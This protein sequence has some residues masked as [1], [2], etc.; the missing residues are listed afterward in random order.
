MDMNIKLKYNQVRMYYESGTGGS[1]CICARQT[2]HVHSPDVST[3]LREMTSWPSLHLESVT[4]NRKSDSVNRCIFRAYLK[5]SLNRPIPAKSSSRSDLKR[6]SIEPVWR[7]RPNKN[8]GYKNNT[9][10]LSIAIWMR[11]VP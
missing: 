9:W 2:F 4:P 5:N 11:S 7:G 8:K 3:F 6:Q 1:C 10:V